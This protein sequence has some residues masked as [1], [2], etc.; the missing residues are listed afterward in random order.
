MAIKFSLY[1]Y[2][3]FFAA[4]SP[5]FISTYLLL[6]S[7]FQ[8]NIRGI[9]FL[10]GN[11]IASFFGMGIKAAAKRPRGKLKYLDKYNNQT[12][13]NSLPPAHD[14]CDVFEPAMESLKHY[15]MPSSHAVF[16]G[17]LLT[18]LQ[19]GIQSNPNKPGIPFFVLLSVLGGMDLFF[20]ASSRC[21]SGLDIF[22]GL[23]IGGAIGAA[24]FFFVKYLWPDGEKV[25]YFAKDDVN[26]EKCKLGKQKF[27]CKKN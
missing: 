15:G 24:W 4:L 23:I 19:L 17:Y 6:S 1:N 2:S 8:G 16:F 20:R 9:V 5:L 25:V 14:F 10:I 21:D 22:A 26:V 7:L 27:V 11:A 13:A 18:Y 12:D 3:I